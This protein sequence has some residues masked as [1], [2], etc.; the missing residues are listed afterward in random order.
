ML[1]LKP[2]RNA[3]NMVRFVLPL[4]LLRLVG[5]PPPVQIPRVNKVTGRS[6]H[7]GPKHPVTAPFSQTIRAL[8]DWESP[9]RVFLPDPGWYPGIFEAG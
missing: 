8:L 6:R 3:I 9:L 7:G 5:L 2:F 4:D 1:P